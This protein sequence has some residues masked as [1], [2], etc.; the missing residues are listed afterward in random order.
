LSL[1]PGWHVVLL[2]NAEVRGERSV[3]VVEYWGKDTA[4]PSLHYST[5]P[6]SDP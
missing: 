3:G 6:V 1:S 5:T 4:T 2:G